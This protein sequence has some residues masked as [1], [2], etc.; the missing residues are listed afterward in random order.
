MC[1]CSSDDSDAGEHEDAEAKAER[2]AQRRRQDAATASQ[3][4]AGPLAAE[5]PSDRHD[6]GAQPGRDAASGRGTSAV[7]DAGAAAAAPAGRQMRQATSSAAQL[8]HGARNSR[9]FGG[10]GAGNGATAGTQQQPDGGGGGRPGGVSI[11][12]A[13]QVTTGSMAAPDAAPSAD[14]PTGRRQS[15]IQLAALAAA[16]TRA[17]D[18]PAAQPAASSDDEGSGGEAAAPDA[19]RPVPGALTRA[20]MGSFQSFTL[21]ISATSTNQ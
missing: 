7:A 17:A 15:G 2:L 9:L 12:P 10:S 14:G 1:R 19:M 3:F 6:G 21:V 20:A 5:L 18:Q 4:G 13:S 8:S 16:G 11:G